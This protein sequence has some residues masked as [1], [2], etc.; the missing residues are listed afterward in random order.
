[1]SSPSILGKPNRAVVLIANIQAD[2]REG[3]ASALYNLALEIERGR[4]AKGVSISGSH[5][6]GWIIQYLENEGP[7]HDEYF[8][9]LNRYLSGEASPDDDSGWTPVSKGLPE[10][11]TLVAN[12]Y[13]NNGTV[14][15]GQFNDKQRPTHYFV[16]PPLPVKEQS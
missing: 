5:S 4:F 7:T 3:M 14:W 13:Q 1:M 8:I 16:L 15:A 11:G 2:T 9:Q 6:S 10:P 12:Y